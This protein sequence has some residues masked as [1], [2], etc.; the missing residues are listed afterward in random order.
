[1]NT[2]EARL[3]GI[4]STLVGFLLCLVGTAVVLVSVF[5]GGENR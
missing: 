5:S 4:Q 1:M 3:L 2:T